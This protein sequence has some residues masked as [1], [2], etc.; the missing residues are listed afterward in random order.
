MSEARK[1]FVETLPLELGTYVFSSDIARHI[2]V[3]RLNVGER[4]V[5]FDRAGRKAHVY[6]EKITPDE[7]SGVVKN[8]V[9]AIAADQ[10]IILIM[11]LPK[12]GQLDNA[13]RMATELG[14]TE[15]RL[16][17][18]ERSIP[19]WDEART[20]KKLDRLERIVQ[21]AAQQSERGDVP[22]IGSPMPLADV[23][24][25]QDDALKLALVVSAGAGLPSLGEHAHR[26]KCVA[27][28]PEGG[29][30]R[31]EHQ[32]LSEQGY[33]CVHLGQT[34]LRVETAVA[35]ALALVAFG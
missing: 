30:T 34:V 18:T 19:K 17:Y 35:S 6:I 33:Q 29:F 31:A 4:C 32:F 20:Q 10:K 25:V 14:V 15:I 2:K 26:A 23:V 3:L 11:G 16:A 7:V 22:I 1:F 13:L 27:I 12:A 24:E 5:L 8:F 9:E 21:Q 28:G